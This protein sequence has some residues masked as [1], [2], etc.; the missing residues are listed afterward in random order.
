MIEYTHKIKNEM[1]TFEDISDRLE[2]LKNAYKDKKCYIIG[3]GPSLKNYDVDYVKD[4]LKDEL[5]ITI[6]QAYELL[7][8]IVDI[9]ILNFANYRE[10]DYKNNNPIV[11]WELFE[12]FHVD[13][14]FKNNLKCDI[15]L[16]TSGNW[17]RDENKKFKESQCGSLSFDNWTLDKTLNRQF[18]P[19]LIFE[20]AIPI[21]LHLGVNKIITLG[22]DIGDISKFDGIESK[23][24]FQEHFDNSSEKIVYAKT[25]QTKLELQTIIDSTEFLNKWLKNKG[26]DF[27]IISDRNPAHKSIKRGEL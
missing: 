8:D 20:M 23:E 18:G 21:A 3:A 17:E 11:M 24:F 5:V 16:P 25:P 9:Q 19:S 6:K 2:V 26:V 12:Q 27:E 13:M 10:Y 22:W 1:L 14:I 4:K 7:E 15:M